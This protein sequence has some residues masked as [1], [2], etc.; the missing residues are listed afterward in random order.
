MAWPSMDHCHGPLLALA[1]STIITESA[2]GANKFMDNAFEETLS[3]NHRRQ[4]AV[5]RAQEKRSPLKAG[6]Y[7][8]IQY[9]IFECTLSC[10]EHTNKT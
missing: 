4:S 2:I 1:W 6:F 8:S 10:A 5:T 9:S 3:L 7:A